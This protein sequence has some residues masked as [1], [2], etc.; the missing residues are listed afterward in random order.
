MVVLGGWLLEV[1]GCWVGEKYWSRVMAGGDDGWMG[2]RLEG[3]MAEG[4]SGG[5]IV[6]EMTMTVSGD[7]SR[8]VKG[9]LQVDI[10]F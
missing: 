3:M 10:Y 6:W 9:L 1:D 5:R 8:I 4:I 2:G 7:D